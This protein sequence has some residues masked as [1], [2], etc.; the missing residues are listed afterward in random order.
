MFSM[1][2]GAGNLV[3]PLTLGAK[4]VNDNVF[5]SLGLAITAII[6]P[7]LGLISIVFYNGDRETF[8]RCIGK[9]SSFFVTLLLLCLMGPFGG[10]PRCISVAHGGFSLFMPEFPYMWFSVLFCTINLFIIWNYKRIV[11]IIGLL[12]SPWLIGS[13]AVII[14]AG[15]MHAPQPPSELEP[16]SN[17]SSF[18]LGFMTGYHMMDLLAAFFFSATTVRYL[19]DH[20]K[21]NEVSHLTMPLS[22][23]TCIIGISLLAIVYY[24]FI[25]LGARFAGLLEGVDPHQMLVA[26]AGTSLGPAAIPVI[27]IT[28]ILACLTTVSVLVTL[29]ADFLNVD[30]SREKLGRHPAIIITLIMSF[31]VSLL[32]FHGLYKALGYILEVVYPALIALAIG[33]ILGKVTGKRFGRYFFWSVFWI[34][35]FFEIWVSY[36]DILA[37]VQTLLATLFI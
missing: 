17:F 6:V 10:I 21:A 13:I 31:F 36:K 37:C 33:N 34:S 5:A 19:R 9:K 27:S 18:N 35:F 28:I 25:L 29:F 1:F 26:I 16:F 7:F 11:P 22:T 20:L 30:I 14:I 15:F 2:F 8:F 12:L 4:T 3:F 24:G 23:L 32:G